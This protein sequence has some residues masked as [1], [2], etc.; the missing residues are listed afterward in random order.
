[1]W[2]ENDQLIVCCDETKEDELLF[3]RAA[4]KAG[5]QCEIR[6]FTNGGLALDYFRQCSVKGPF[7]S[8][9]FIRYQLADTSGG[10]L[11][12]SFASCQVLEWF[13]L[14]F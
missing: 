9:I 6:F 1:M 3:R 13:R 4:K 12:D 7:P 5:V 8:V 14:F 10:N 2:F 11:I